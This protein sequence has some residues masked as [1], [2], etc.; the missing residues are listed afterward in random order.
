[1]WGEGAGWVSRDAGAGV[2]EWGAKK[3]T[4]KG[5]KEM[6]AGVGAQMAQQC[7]AEDHGGPGGGLGAGPRNNSQTHRWRGGHT[8][9]S[10]YAYQ[11]RESKCRTEPQ[12]WM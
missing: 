9:R 10:P 8:D 4:Q 5:R 2:R 1:M 3:L 12:T 7:A 11:H 6:E